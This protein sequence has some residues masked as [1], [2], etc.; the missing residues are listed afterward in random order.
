MRLAIRAEPCEVLSQ[1]DSVA[2]CIVVAVC[3]RICL[4]IPIR[5]DGYSI[6]FVLDD[7]DDEVSLT[8]NVCS[9]QMKKE[10]ENRRNST[11]EEALTRHTV[12][13]YFHSSDDVV[14]M[15]IGE[16]CADDADVAVGKEVLL[17]H[18][19]DDYTRTGMLN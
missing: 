17:T 11:I 13:G 5:S 10:D 16:H 14:Y 15:G 6:G 7:Q 9:W 1:G 3:C 4:R 19:S 18:I 8:G 12:M 2:F